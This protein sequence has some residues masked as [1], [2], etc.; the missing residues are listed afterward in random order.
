MRPV[1]PIYPLI[2]AFFILFQEMVVLRFPWKTH[3]S[4][5]LIKQD[6]SGVGEIQV[7]AMWQP[8]TMVSCE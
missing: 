7:P 8:D 6:G 5:V 3:L 4:Q 1:A 2:G